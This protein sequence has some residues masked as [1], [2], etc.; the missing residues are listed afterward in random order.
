MTTDQ[1]T[2]HRLG[3]W[4]E[5][6]RTRLPEHVIEAVIVELP[7]NP[8]HRGR[9]PAR[10]SAVPTLTRWALTAAAVVATGI[11]G[12]T[13]LGAWDLRPIVPTPPLVSPTPAASPTPLVTAG[14]PAT[15]WPGESRRLPGMTYSPA[16]VYG[17]EG[18][19]DD[20]AGMHRFAGSLEGSRETT[21]L[22]WKVGGDCLGTNDGQ[23]VRPVRVGGWEGVS[24]EPYTPPVTFGRT[25][26]DETTRAYALA[27]GDRTLCLYL[28]WNTATTDAER[29]AA[30]R[31]IDTLRLEPV[32]ASW[33]RIIFDLDAGW[34]T[35]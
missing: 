25:E 16:G 12:G 15:P 32:S 11:V 13:M 19:I 29:M 24:V 28:T 4:L 17:W 2:L 20:G 27:A 30:E 21:E 3:V 1:E 34:D 33:V 31:V 5:E 7:S 18:G 14:P 8:Q 26:G 22:V 9:W 35:G 23:P 6:G 10:R